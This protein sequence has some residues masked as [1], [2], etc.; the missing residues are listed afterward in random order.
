M[1]NTN[2]TSAQHRAETYVNSLTEEQ[3]QRLM[4]VFRAEEIEREN[5]ERA[6]QPIYN[7]R[8]IEARER[9]WPSKPKR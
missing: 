7:L 1:S 2:K 6:A 8:G 3:Q 9:L 4:D 5:V